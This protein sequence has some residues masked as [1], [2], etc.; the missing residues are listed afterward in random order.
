[1]KS[2]KAKIMSALV[3]LK[4][5]SLILFYW[6]LKGLKVNCLAQKSLAEKFTAIYRDRIWAGERD[7]EIAI[8]EWL[9]FK[10]NSWVTKR[11]TE[12]TARA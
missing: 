11:F 1:M 4:S 12:N 8:W 9:I 2:A 3:R 7:Q 10:R 6:K 5:E